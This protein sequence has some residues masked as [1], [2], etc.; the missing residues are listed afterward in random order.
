[1]EPLAKDGREL[2]EEK[3]VTITR[4]IYKD[5]TGKILPVMEIGGTLNPDEIVGLCYKAMITLT[6]TKK[7]DSYMEEVTE[8]P[9]EQ[10]QPIT[11]QDKPNY[12]G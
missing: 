10:P 3:Q 11:K 2:L 7:E 5:K 12:M 1:M 4:R 6:T 8:V 9:P